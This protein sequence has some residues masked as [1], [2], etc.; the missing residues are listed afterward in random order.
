MRNYMMACALSMSL[1]FTGCL[2]SSNDYSKAEPFKNIVGEK[3]II[4]GEMTLRSRKKHRYYFVKNTL[5]PPFADDFFGETVARIPVGSIVKIKSVKMVEADGF[6][7]FYAIGDIHVEDNNFSTQF[8]VNIGTCYI[9][10]EYVILLK[11]PWDD[12]TTPLKTLYYWDGC[13]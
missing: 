7:S 2:I 5:R 1:L 9:G 4:Q 8:E 13:K 12:A 3:H 10:D 6:K 11:T